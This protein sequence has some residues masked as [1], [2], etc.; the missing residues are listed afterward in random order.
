MPP[1]D[2]PATPQS[3]RPSASNASRISTAASTNSGVQYRQQAQ[4]YRAEAANLRDELAATENQS[5]FS[6]NVPAP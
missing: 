5:Q 3:P 6:A 4:K 2:P 1:T